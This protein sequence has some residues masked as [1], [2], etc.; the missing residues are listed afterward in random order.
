MA[1]STAIKENNTELAAIRVSVDGRLIYMELTN[2][3]IIG[4]LVDRFKL[5]SQA[6]GEQ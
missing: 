1:P 2:G 5:L 3:R 4:F 6:T